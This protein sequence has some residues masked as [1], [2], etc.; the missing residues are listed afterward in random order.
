MRLAFSVPLSACPP[1]ESI[2]KPNKGPAS[3]GAEQAP[4][5]AAQPVCLSWVPLMPHSVGGPRSEPPGVVTVLPKPA[6][7]WAFSS[8]PRVCFTFLLQE[9]ALSEWPDWMKGALVRGSTAGRTQE[10]E[11]SCFNQVVRTSCFPVA[12]APGVDMPEPLLRDKGLLLH[13]HP[14]PLPTQCRG[15]PLCPKTMASFQGG[16][17]P[18]VRRECGRAL[19]VSTCEPLVSALAG[20]GTAGELSETP[21]PEAHTRR[22]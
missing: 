11:P 2:G 18:G 13:G 7:V 15:G 8:L 9:P 17:I 20:T 3:S 1:R 5:S 12:V 21:M 19:D 16:K 10:M 6:R 22:S 4:G 14:L